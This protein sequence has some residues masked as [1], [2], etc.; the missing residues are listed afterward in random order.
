LFNGALHMKLWHFALALMMSLSLAPFHAMAQAPK[1]RELFVLPEI[2][3]DVHDV[4]FSPDGSR[5]V[6]AGRDGR[7]ILWDLDSKRSLAVLKCSDWVSSI[8]FSPDG[9]LIAIRA[10]NGEL[11][12]WDAITH[13]KQVA[14]ESRNDVTSHA[15]SP[16]GK[17]LVTTTANGVIRF[18][19]P[20]LRKQI[21]EI[22]DHDRTP[23][24]MVCRATFSQNGLRLAIAGLDGKIVIWDTKT[25]KRVLSLEN[26]EPVGS[27][28]FSKDG[29]SLASTDSIWRK[30]NFLV[31]E[32]TLASANIVK[33]W[34]VSSGK[35]IK[36]LAG[37]TDNVAQV[38]FFEDGNFL[39]SA[40]YDGTVRVWS[41]ASGKETQ[42]IAP[43]GHGGIFAIEISK[44]GNRVAFGG[45]DFSVHIL[46]VSK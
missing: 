34:D 13:D 23:Y 6:S 27:L 2:G 12:L 7:A 10:G 44:D 31:P 46:Q 16:D 30:I 42:T 39:A 9:K 5:L 28:C 45:A 43:R 29:K 21:A 35:V 25:L 14:L 19:D 22:K 18:W 41:L 40:S 17:T 15:F 11:I 36:Q 38:Q 26:G 32:P 4:A 33:I 3:N 8:S 1:L 20:K 37:H 24:S